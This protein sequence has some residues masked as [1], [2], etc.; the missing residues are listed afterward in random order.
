MVVPYALDGKR[1]LSGQFLETI[2]HVL[3]SMEQLV[4]ETPLAL[5]KRCELQEGVLDVL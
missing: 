5:G 2:P 1:A 4:A 3:F